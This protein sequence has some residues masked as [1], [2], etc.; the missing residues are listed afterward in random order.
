MITG[1]SRYGQ[2]LGVSGN[3]YH[4]GLAPLIGQGDAGSNPAAAA[5]KKNIKKI[6]FI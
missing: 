4:L 6:F 5:N 1:L 3:E 2:P